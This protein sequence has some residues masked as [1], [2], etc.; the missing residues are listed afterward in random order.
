[1][2]SRSHSVPQ[3]PLRVLL[4]SHDSYGL[5]HL[6][7]STTLATA[8]VRQIPDAAVLIATGSPVATYFA[9]PAGVDLIKLPSITKD[10]CGAYVPRSLPGGL[11]FTL[12]MRRRLLAEA[13][14]SFAPH[15]LVVDHQVIGLHG[16]LLPVL[17]QARLAGTRSILGLR[18]V[19]DDP[20]VVAREWSRPE[21]RRALAESYDRIC[22]YGSPTVFDSRR[23]YPVPPELCARVS[24]TGYIVREAPSP[25]V[26]PLPAERPQV[27]VTVGGGEDGGSRLQAYLDCLRVGPVTWDS[28]IVLGPL[29]DPAAGRHIKRQARQ[30]DGV[31]VHAF[32]GD[33]PRLLAESNA[34]VSMAGYNSTAE[35]LRSGVS[36]V[37]LPRT[38]PRREQL[39]R[40]SRLAQLGLVQCL[41][42][43]DPRSLRAAVRSAL[44]NVGGTRSARGLVP[45]DGDR[46]LVA[47][48]AELLGRPLRQAAIAS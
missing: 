15:L 39:L 30:I 12:T 8:L 45:L 5:G 2:S 20:A 48:A 27:L 25:S 47:I 28:V 31:T 46:R 13:F 24:F 16:E 36:A 42:A 33:M 23:E 11:D 22:I 19:I 10:P 21:V 18:D 26:R 38:A 40:A 9:P 44:A 14:S 29:L 4:Y 41:P 17:E 34:V 3:T 37:L 43:P 35:I 7:R 6:R 32:H 1:M